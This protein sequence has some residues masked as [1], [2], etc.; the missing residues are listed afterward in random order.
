MKTNEVCSRL[1]ITKKALRVYENE[2]LLTA[3]RSDNNYR[4][5]TETDLIRIKSIQVLRDL[6]FSIKD[7]K[8]I[9]QKLGGDSKE[10]LLMLFYMQLKTT[11]M[12]ISQLKKTKRVLTENINTI[13]SGSHEPDELTD[14]IVK[15]MDN[16]PYNDFTCSILKEWDFDDMA[17][18]YIEN[19]LM[20]DSAYSASILAGRELISS[21]D[22]SLR[23]ID[24]GGGNGHMWWELPHKNIS[25][26][27]KSVEMLKEAK[28]H[29]PHSKSIL[30]DIIETSSWRYGKFD[31]VTAFFLL[32][33]IDYS[34]QKSAI[35]NILSFIDK[36]GRAVIIDRGFK[37]PEERSSFL[38]T[39]SAEKRKE[40][41]EEF[42]LS[43][44]TLLPYIEYKG[45]T[46]TVNQIGENI[47]VIEIAEKHHRNKTK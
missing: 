27:D 18:N 8:I 5:Y 7:I 34:N 9:M 22:E 44:D 39:C 33:H 12:K 43:L 20:Q 17:D 26:L 19:Y 15:C 2:G 16:I 40:I 1:G 42:Y 23:I 4:E 35:D 11:D 6:G 24:I 21:Y 30:N 14:T 36:N 46:T 38:N 37:T 29:L 13:L 3:S 32:H 31:L 10:D 45:F 47:Y 25:I 28:K 41:L